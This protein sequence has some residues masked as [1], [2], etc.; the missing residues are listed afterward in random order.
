MGSIPS[1][2][3]NHKKQKTRTIKKNQKLKKPKTAGVGGS[4]V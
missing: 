1:T 3:K 2:A 4:H